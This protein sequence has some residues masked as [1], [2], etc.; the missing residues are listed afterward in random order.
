MG[1]R[2]GDVGRNGVSG[3]YSA[4]FQGIGLAFRRDFADE[5]GYYSLN[6]G[7]ASC[8]FTTSLTHDSAFVQTVGT[9]ES[10][11]SGAI[12]DLG[13]G[14]HFRLGGPIFLGVEAGTMLGSAASTTDRKG[15]LFG[16]PSKQAIHDDSVEPLSAFRAMLSLSV[17]L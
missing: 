16:A 7:L 4:S 14:V 3:S 6:L 5:N 15:Y 9:Y 10:S 1:S 12:V 8:S 11:G 2:S 13:A 17:F